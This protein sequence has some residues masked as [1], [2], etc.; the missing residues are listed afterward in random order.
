M[1]ATTYV[2]KMHTKEKYLPKNILHWILSVNYINVDIYD[3]GDGDDDYE[4]D[5]NDDDD[6]GDSDD[7]A[8]GK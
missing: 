8:N 5:D 6:G 4:D 2:I 1:A 7:D 3:D